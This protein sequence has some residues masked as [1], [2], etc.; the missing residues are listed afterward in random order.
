MDSDLDLNFEVL[1]SPLPLTLA[2]I[3]YY[4]GPT[5]PTKMILVALC[6]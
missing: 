3:Y 1:S 2:L 5:V 4:L 6:H